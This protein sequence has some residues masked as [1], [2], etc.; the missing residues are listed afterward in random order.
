[1]KKL[2]VWTTIMVVGFFGVLAFVIGAIFYFVSHYSTYLTKNQVEGCIIAMCFGGVFGLGVITWVAQSYYAHI[3]QDEYTKRAE[4]QHEIRLEELEVEKMQAQ[5]KQD[6]REELANIQ[7]KIWA[8]WQKYLFSMCEKQEDGSMVIPLE[9]VER[10]QKQ[11]ETSYSDLPETSK[12][13][14]R[15][16]VDKFIHLICEYGTRK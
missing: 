4:I 14:D 15:H 5:G 7:H 8:H 16:Q 9:F 11:I 13:S 6:L 3:E 1:M 10:W 12:D 2:N